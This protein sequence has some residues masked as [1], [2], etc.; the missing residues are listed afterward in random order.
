MPGPESQRRDFIKWE[1]ALPK[2]FST[3][4]ALSEML[5]IPG[6]AQNATFLRTPF[7]PQKGSIE[8]LWEGLQNHRQGSIEPLASNPPF[9]GYPLKILPIIGLCTFV[10]AR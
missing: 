6:K 3:F 4:F 9:L 2:S 5:Q 1:S 8:P 10:G 7:G